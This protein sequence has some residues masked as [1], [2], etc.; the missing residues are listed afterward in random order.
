MK[1][2][3]EVASSPRR[4]HI[5]CG[6]GRRETRHE[7]LSSICSLKNVDW[8]RNALIHSLELHYMSINCKRLA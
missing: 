3:D 7:A 2:S 8:I 4:L 5:F 1:D 6:G